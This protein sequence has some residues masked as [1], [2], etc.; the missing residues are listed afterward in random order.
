M[1]GVSGGPDSICLLHL[2]QTLAPSLNLTLHVAHLNHSLREQAAADDAA[3]VAD[4]AQ[5]W[6]LPATIQ[7]EDVAAFARHHHLNLED[8]ARRRR[9]TFLAQVAGQ[10]QASKIAVAH[11]ADDQ[12][13]T[14][15]MRFLRGAGLTGLRGMQPHLPMRE[16]GLDI[17]ED[18]TLIRPLLNTPK[19]DINAYL[20]EH[21]LPYRVD[22]TNQDEALLRN[23]VRHTLLPFLETYNP[24][25]R[26]N[27]RNMATLM[28]ADAEI[29]AQATDQA[30]ASISTFPVTGW[31]NLELAS[32]QRLPLA[33]QRATLRRAIHH[34]QGHLADISFVHLE[35]A[36]HLLQQG[37]VGSRQSLP[38][39]LQLSINYQ[40]AAL[41]Q[42]GSTPP[43]PNLPR[44]TPGQQVNLLVPGITPLTAGWAVETRLLK[45]DQLSPEELKQTDRWNA[46]FDA[47][48]IGPSLSLRTR[49][50]GDQFSPFGTAG[51]AQRL[52]TFMINQKIP[53]TERA[54][55]PLL[56]SA[57]GEIHWVC[58]WRTGN[59]ARITDK[60]QQVLRIT[61]HHSPDFQNRQQEVGE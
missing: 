48:I 21:Q 40:H 30:W 29:L 7:Q 13:E 35:Q 12:V 22:Q 47:G 14:L 52:K 51:P 6:Q 61:L 45:R 55:L 41:F 43:C 15:I 32:W 20:R 37:K 57:T 60:T 46:Y 1:V 38:H 9:Y 2:L 33:L 23:R 3:F 58:G 5:Q 44:L 54:T 59:S 42:A 53:L 36:L 31:V 11:H 56:L 25:L 17:A 26:Q 24:N 34:V 18:I 10:V 49:H 8:A 4:L 28:Q 50:T 27:L 39:G 19:L 16:L